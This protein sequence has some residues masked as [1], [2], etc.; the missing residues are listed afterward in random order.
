MVNVL[1]TDALGLFL[2]QL[3]EPAWQSWLLTGAALCE[4][5]MASVQRGSEFVGRS[6]TGAAQSRVRP[7]KWSPHFPFSPSE[8]VGH[9]L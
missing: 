4:L 1:K 6:W 2:A 9:A 3:W 7:G 8:E 5:E